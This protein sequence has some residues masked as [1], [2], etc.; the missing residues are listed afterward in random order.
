MG[1]AASKAPKRAF[2]KG[3]LQQRV[4]KVEPQTAQADPNAATSQAPVQFQEQTGD[5]IFSNESCVSFAKSLQA[6]AA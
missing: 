3:R 2:P 5:G 4:E 1:S 6:H